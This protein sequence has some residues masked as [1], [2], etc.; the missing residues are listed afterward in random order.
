MLYYRSKENVGRIITTNGK[1]KTQTTLTLYLR[2]EKTITIMWRVILNIRIIIMV[3]VII[4]IS[5]ADK[6]PTFHKK[7]DMISE[8][9]FIM[10]ILITIIMM[11]MIMMLLILNK[12]TIKLP[13]EFKRLSCIIPCLFI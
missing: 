11:M 10:I 13:I 2:I 6:I 5:F 4:N 8:P 1:I 9:S 3:F 12:K 7:S